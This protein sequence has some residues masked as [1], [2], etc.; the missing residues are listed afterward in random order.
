MGRMGYGYGSEL[1]LLRWMGRHRNKFNDEVSK[2][3][4]VKGEKILNLRVR[5][6]SRTEN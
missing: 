6:S 4:G 5:I 3:I 2:A 1:H